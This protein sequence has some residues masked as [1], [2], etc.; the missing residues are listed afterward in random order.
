MNQALDPNYIPL[1]PEEE[2]QALANYASRELDILN[3]KKNMRI[4][5]KPPTFIDRYKMGKKPQGKFLN[6]SAGKDKEQKK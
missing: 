6:F 1:T 2:K 3:M 4:V 5:V